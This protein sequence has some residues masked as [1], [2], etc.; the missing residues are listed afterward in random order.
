MKQKTQKQVG[1]AHNGVRVN[2]V[3][4]EWGIQHEYINSRRDLLVLIIVR[5]W[6]TGC[7]LYYDSI[8]AAN[9]LKPKA[10]NLLVPIGGFLLV[11]NG[12][13]VLPPCAVYEERKIH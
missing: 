11:L 1:Y 12:L 5:S 3:I 4:I 10:M 13:C 6:H 8:G 7:N 2:K 9:T